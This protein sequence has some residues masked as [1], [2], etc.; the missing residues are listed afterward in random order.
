MGSGVNRIVV[1]AFTG[2]GA[3]LNV[4]TVGFRPKAVHV[5]NAGGLCQAWWTERMADAAAIKQITD[6]TIS[7][8][9]SNGITPLSNGFTLGADADLNVSGE[10]C[11]YIAQE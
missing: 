1:G 6:G 8:L 4:R 2:T 9:T 7:A 3:A 11:H 5:I 10:L